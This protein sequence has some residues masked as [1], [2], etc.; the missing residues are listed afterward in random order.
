MTRIPLLCAMTLWMTVFGLHIDAHAQHPDEPTV[1]LRDLLTEARQ[2]NPDIRAARARVNAAQYRVPQAGALPNPSVMY[3][4]NN[5]GLSSFSIGRTDM[6][7]TGLSFVQAIPFPGKR[8]LRTQVAATDVQINEASATATEFDA[9]SQ[10]KVAYY[11]LYLIHQSLIIVDKN[12]ELLMTFARTA[13]ARY[14]VGTGI[15]QDV[16]KAQVEISRLIERR[17]R[18]EQR[19]QAVEARINSLLARPSTTPVGRPAE[20]TR[21]PLQSTLDDLITMVDRQAPR[22]RTQDRMIERQQTGVALAKRDYYPDFDVS[23]SWL[24]RGGLPDMYQVRVGVE[25]PLYYRRKQRNMVAETQAMVAEAQAERDATKQMFLAEVRDQYAMAQT[26]N[27]QADL[28][29]QA[30]IPQATLSLESAVAGYEVGKVDFLT[31]LDNLMSL[32]E[33][34][35]SYYEKVVEHQ[36]ALARL[37]PLV[38]ATLVE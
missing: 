33:D 10:L 25:L 29:E 7:M 11:D 17:K 36:Q 22:V 13:E 24:T 14:A 34:E 19:Q 30:I 23:A 21:T 4:L 5:I 12:R 8:G 26:A 1:T 6:S 31:L 35:L 18:L 15:Q 20:V 9:L 2:R 28:Y 37:E 38:G 16:L 27:E 32:L 3:E